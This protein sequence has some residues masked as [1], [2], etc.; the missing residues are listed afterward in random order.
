MLELINTGL[1][2]NRPTL[3]SRSLEHDLI[4]A[5]LHFIIRIRQTFDIF[6]FSQRSGESVVVEQF[7]IDLDHRCNLCV[8]ERTA[9]DSVPPPYI[10]HIAI[11]IED[12]RFQQLM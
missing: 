11:D 10:S 9:T 1:I 3:M 7:T 5:F 6:D 4:N 8:V 2:A 12:A